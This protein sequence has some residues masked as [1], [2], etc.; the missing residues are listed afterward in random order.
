VVEVF[1]LENSLQCFFGMVVPMQANVLNETGLLIAAASV[2]LAIF[3]FI[4]AA[5]SYRRERRR[6]LLYLMT[7]ILL[8]AVKDTLSAVNEATEYLASNGVTMLFTFEHLALLL[9]FFVLLAL[10]VGLIKK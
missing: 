4:V 3:L 5:F 2:F 7:A 8:F 1:F 6:R 10:F 9:D